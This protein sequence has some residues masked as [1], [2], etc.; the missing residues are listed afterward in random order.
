[1]PYHEL[2]DIIKSGVCNNHFNYIKIHIQNGLDGKMRRLFILNKNITKI[3]AL[4]VCAIITGLFVS[5]C[6]PE[7]Q[8]QNNDVQVP[9]PVAQ[10]QQEPSSPVRIPTENMVD[11]DVEDDISSGKMVSYDVAS[12]GRG[13]PFMPYNEMIEYERARNSAIAEARAKNAQIF[14]IKNMQNY[15]I[16][17]QDDISPYKFNLPVPPTSLDTGSVAAKITNTKVVGILFNTKSPSAIINV[18]SKDYLVRPGDKIIGQEYKVIKIT[19]T[20]VTAAMGSNVYSAAIGEMFT[21]DEL[22]TNQTDI[23]NLK[24]RFGGRKI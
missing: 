18:D 12:I 19:P 10:N 22:E 9:Q 21:K 7:S 8:T 24:E 15:R 3:L 4:L 2:Y 20:W 17:E 5:G 14:K 23:Y 1:M 6:G 11:I 13:N 16:R